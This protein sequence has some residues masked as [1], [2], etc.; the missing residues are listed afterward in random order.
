MGIPFLAYYLP[1]PMDLA[2]IE[3]VSTYLGR[4][5]LILILRITYAT[6]WILG[7]IVLA[8][9]AERDRSHHLPN[10]VFYTSQK[11]VDGNGI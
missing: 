9:R 11:R 4:S 3:T 2:K 6:C 1:V 10:A 8:K 5:H 7:V